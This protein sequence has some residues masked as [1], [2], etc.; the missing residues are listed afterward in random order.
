MKNYYQILNLDSSA[1]L[2]EI[3]RAYKVYASK[4]HPDKHGGNDD[5]F[6]ER[7]HEI[8]E[9]Y[10]VLS[11]SSKRRFLDDYLASFN[12]EQAATTDT[13]DVKQPEQ[14][15][16]A[17]YTKTKTTKTK[18]SGRYYYE[19]SY[20]RLRAGDHAEALTNIDKAIKL[21]P[22]NADFVLARGIIFKKLND[23]SG[24]Q[25]WVTRA[26]SLGSTRARALKKE[27]EAESES[28]LDKISTPITTIALCAFIIEVGLYNT[29]HLIYSE[30]EFTAVLVSIS[31]GAIFY[32]FYINRA[33]KKNEDKVRNPLYRGMIINSCIIMGAVMV[34]GVP[35]FLLTIFG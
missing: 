1:S 5:F 30:S 27:L 33:L 25:K 13:C 10:S 8:S 14:T 12:S 22:E 3:K 17:S 20:S 2:E 24:Y 32:I 6:K 9:A 28:Y 29:F 35:V 26:S 4:Y 18:D 31:V 7:F 11:D 19:H 21:E 34:L 23:Y 16:K 15:K